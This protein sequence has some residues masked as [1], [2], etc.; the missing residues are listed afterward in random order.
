MEAKVWDTGTSAWVP[1]IIGAQG[2][3]G[4]TG[5]Q[6]PTGPSGG[7]TGPAGPPSPAST[8]SIGAGTTPVTSSSTQIL[9]SNGA[10]KQFW[11]TNTS[12][13]LVVYLAFGSTAVYGSGIALYPG[14]QFTTQMYSGMVSGIISDTGSAY[15]AFV[16]V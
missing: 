15:V 5:A 11:V 4:P 12:T 16:E 1:A 13:S 7:T 8:A 9:A 10:R 2:Y 14:Q 6:G 3:Q